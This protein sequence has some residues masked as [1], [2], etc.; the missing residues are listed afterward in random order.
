M[1]T[2]TYNIGSKIFRGSSLG[3]L[4]SI[5]GLMKRSFHTYNVL[6]LPPFMKPNTKDEA[7]AI[8]KKQLRIAYDKGF[9]NKKL[10]PNG[11]PVLRIVTAGEFNYNGYE[12]PG[13]TDLQGNYIPPETKYDAK[14]KIPLDW[15][16]AMSG[17]F[18]DYMKQIDPSVVFC[19][20]TTATDTG[21][22]SI[23]GIPIYENRTFIAGGTLGLSELE[24]GNN[25]IDISKANESNL[26]GGNGFKFRNGSGAKILTIKDITGGRPACI[27][28]AT[29]LDLVDFLQRLTET[30]VPQVI[31]NPSA[32]SPIDNTVGKA[33][34]VVVDIT[35][36]PFG[37]NMMGISTVYSPSIE[38]VSKYPITKSLLENIRLIPGGE[39]LS[40]MARNFLMKFIQ[41]PETAFNVVNRY[42]AENSKI[43]EVEQGVKIVEIDDRPLP[44]ISDQLL[45]L[46]NGSA[47]NSNGV[48]SI[49]PNKPEIRNDPN[50][51]SEPNTGEGP[52]GID[53]DRPKRAI[54]VIK[55]MLISGTL[56]NS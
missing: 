12:T 27:G 13:H 11:T 18:T 54:N 36:P 49:L 55:D 2:I 28:V 3:N 56:N 41:N 20:G 24:S 45:D 53:I 32:A 1:R 33:E 40:D 4:R 37:E 15:Y 38:V 21:E 44:E 26:D 8:A 31:L 25:I 7:I 23:D 48:I 10:D 46:I 16:K 51:P 19:P 52:K 22:K 9:F 17:I 14:G 29:C 50:I 39:K 47:K 42:I 5:N 35:R 34:V 30:H 6:M 43:S